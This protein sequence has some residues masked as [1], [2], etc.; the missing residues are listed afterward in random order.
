MGGSGLG[1]GLE[2]PE[3]NGVVSEIGSRVGRSSDWLE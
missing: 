3:F 2:I 1:S